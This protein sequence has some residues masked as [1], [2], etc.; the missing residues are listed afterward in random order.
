MSV[1][2]KR[3]DRTKQLMQGL[4]KAATASVKES[5]LLLKSIARE[6]VSRRYVK[7]TRQKRIE[8]GREHWSYE[9]ILAERTRAREYFLSRPPKPKPVQ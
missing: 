6:M 8:A 1:T 3:V 7:T 5:A 2:V 9:R 4:E